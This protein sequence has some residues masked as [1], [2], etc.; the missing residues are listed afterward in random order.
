[1]TGYQLRQVHTPSISI[2]YIVHIY[3]YTN[4]HY[5]CLQLFIYSSYLP[6]LYIHYI[7]IYTANHSLIIHGHLQ[8]S[9]ALQHGIHLSILHVYLSYA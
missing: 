3:I 8:T 4:I 5:P 6:F 7:Y 1:M 9:I 2:H